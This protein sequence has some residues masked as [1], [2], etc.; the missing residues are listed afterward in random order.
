MRKLFPSEPDG[1]NTFSIYLASHIALLWKA[2]DKAINKMRWSW[3]LAFE[4]ELQG[5]Q[6]S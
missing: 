2:S 1:M 5:T 4:K 6:N 3:F